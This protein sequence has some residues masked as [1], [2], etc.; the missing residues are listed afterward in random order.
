MMFV[1]IG[2]CSHEVKIQFHEE[3]LSLLFVFFAV[4]ASSAVAFSKVCQFWTGQCFPQYHIIT[5]EE[6]DIINIITAWSD[7]LLLSKTVTKYNNT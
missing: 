6:G 5:V 2:L 1:L 4:I 3:G 7:Q